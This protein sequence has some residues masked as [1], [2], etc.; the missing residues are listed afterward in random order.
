M[1][2]RLQLRVHKVMSG[3]EALSGAVADIIPISNEESAPIYKGVV[4][5]V[6]HSA[7]H[8]IDVVPGRYLVRAYLPSGSLLSQQVDAEA[9]KTTETTLVARVT[10]HEWL[11]WQDLV[12]Q[13]TLE[14][15]QHPSA[16]T[17]PQLLL[18]E[19]MSGEAMWSMVEQVTTT[20]PWSIA[21][22]TVALRD[23][24]AGP[25]PSQSDD[26]TCS[27]L[28]EAP[29]ASADRQRYCIVER[30]GA[31][32]LL[33]LPMPWRRLHRQRGEEPAPIDIAVP[34]DRREPASVAV[35]DAELGPLLGFMASGRLDAA[36]EIIKKGG[37][38]YQQVF[39]ALHRKL[40]NPFAAAAGACLLLQ[41][42]REEAAE[43][44]PWVENL[45]AWFPW[46][47]DGAV[48]RGALRLSNARSNEDLLAAR[49]AFAEG[50]KRGIP[51]LAPV[52]RLLLDG[53]STLVDDP[54]AEA[55]DLRAMLPAIGRAAA[56]MVTDQ[57]FTCLR[58]GCRGLT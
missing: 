25:S 36:R 4:I 17:H 33:S 12:G 47:P 40:E 38:A 56:C 14:K 27:F 22:T 53:A 46:L 31:I 34:R 21:E 30:D 5:P 1:T 28:V 18:A 11:G 19:P 23:I 10:P 42:D 43:W 48:L 15:R 7:S 45:A 20:R 29:G 3:E 26:Q 6:G 35:Q 13:R 37:E 44:H 16:S 24:Q 8:T 55:G 32:D 41:L 52:L 51:T 2:T 9:G 58:L 49:D 39:M 54:D 50:W 57:P